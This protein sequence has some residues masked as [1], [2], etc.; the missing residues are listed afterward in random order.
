MDFS[1]AFDKVGHRHL[2]TKLQGYG[3]TGKMNSSIQNW[4]ADRTQVVV[5]DGEQSGPV[6]VTSRVP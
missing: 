5:V 6:P 3:V 1:K 2:L 4:L